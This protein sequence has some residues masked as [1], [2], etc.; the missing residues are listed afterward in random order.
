[1]I[2]WMLSVSVRSL[3]GT[4]ELLFSFWLWPQFVQQRN[5]WVSPETIIFQPK[6]SVW[7]VFMCVTFTS[8]L[9]LCSETLGSAPRVLK[10]NSRAHLQKQMTLF[11]TC[12]MNRALQLIHIQLTNTIKTWQHHKK[13]FFLN[14]KCYLFLQKKLFK[15][16]TSIK[17]HQQ[18]LK[19]FYNLIFLSCFLE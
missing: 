3:E 17:R 2:F 19:W 15:I 8:H 13:W 14:K 5:L 4:S 9:C 1:M 11:L 18:K 7:S 6:T 10:H 16:K 12:F